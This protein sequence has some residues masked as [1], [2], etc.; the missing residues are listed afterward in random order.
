MQ[1][2]ACIKPAAG[3]DSTD[4]TLQLQLQL[5]L[6]FHLKNYEDAQMLTPNKATHGL[7]VQKLLLCQSIVARNDAA[8]RTRSLCV[9]GN[10]ELL[11]TRKRLRCC[12]PALLHAFL[13][14]KCSLCASF[15]RMRRSCVQCWRTG[16]SSRQTL[17]KVAA[18]ASP[19]LAGDSEA[20]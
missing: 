5:K 8:L 2:L 16:W 7:N 14:A 9:D 4:S 20:L 19:R 17:Q 6:A 13:D 10:S 1:V 3:W 18:A 15:Q 11:W 12:G